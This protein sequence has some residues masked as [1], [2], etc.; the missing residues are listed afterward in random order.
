MGQTSP[1][2]YALLYRRENGNRVLDVV[3]LD[4]DGHAAHVRAFYQN[5]QQ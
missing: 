4:Q 5:Q 1:G 3:E 2:G